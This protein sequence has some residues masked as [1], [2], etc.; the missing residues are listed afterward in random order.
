MLRSTIKNR[1]RVFIYLFFP[2]V[3]HTCSRC[4]DT[5]TNTSNL[6]R[7]T[8]TVYAAAEGLH[9]KNAITEQQEKIPFVN[10]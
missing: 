2:T 1:M 8:R 7:H 5:F 9:V 6:I 4:Y 10:M 3:M